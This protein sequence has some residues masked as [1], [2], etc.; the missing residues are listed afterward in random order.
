MPVFNSDKYLEEAINSIL[1]QSYQ[2]FE[3]LIIND[4]STDNSEKIIKSYK[5]PRIHYVKNNTNLGIIKTRNIGLSL[6]KTPFLALIDS[7]DISLQNRLEIQLDYM[8][9]NPNIDVCG[10]CFYK[11]INN[12]KIIINEQKI[13]KILHLKCCLT[14][15]LLTQL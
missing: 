13:M 3:F 14:V 11:L 9:Q 8:R 4:G 6:I 7:D 15:R 10:T 5:D 1:T 2:N 12:K